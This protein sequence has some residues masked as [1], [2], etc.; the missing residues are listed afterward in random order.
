MKRWVCWLQLYPYDV[1][2]WLE[3]NLLEQYF[4]SCAGYGVGRRLG[5]NVQNFFIH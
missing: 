4:V 1:S 3:G 5:H 2:I